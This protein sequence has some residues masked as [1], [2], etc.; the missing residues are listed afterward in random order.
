MKSFNSMD[1]RLLVITQKVNNE[2]PVLGFFH[3]WLLEMAKR[4][5]LVTVICLEK[6]QYRMPE[7][8]RIFSLGK[9]RGLRKTALIRNFYKIVWRERKQYDAVFVHMNPEYVLLGGIFWFLLR[10]KVFL[11]YNHSKGGFRIWLAGVFAKKVFYTSS[12]AYPSRFKNGEVMPAGIDT[13]LFRSESVTRREQSILSLGRIA[14]VKAI[15]II[16]DAADILHDRKSNFS[17][18]VYG[19]ALPKD[20]EY[21]ES[22][23]KKAKNLEASGIVYFH[24]GIPHY[25]APSVYS[26]HD[27]FV[28]MSPPGLFD[29]TVLEAAACET[30]PIVSSL[31]FKDI[32]P[33]E[34]IVEEKSPEMLA[35]KIRNLFGLSVAKRQELGRR[36][37]AEVIEKHSLEVLMNRVFE[38]VSV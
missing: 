17:L 2:D 4:A 6:G 13:K 34:C 11:W 16:L 23:R 21:Y 38:R 32:L 29:K 5:S 19:D 14:P 31:A 28:N 35:E 7:H 3:G 9:E 1:R 24:D 30:I 36:L 18:S 26:A 15:D 25:K 33:P 8:V 12:F 20:R 27:F 22:L 37:R 10:K